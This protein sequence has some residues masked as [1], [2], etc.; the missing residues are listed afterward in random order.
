M[1]RSKGQRQWVCEAYVSLKHFCTEAWRS[2][3][4]QWEISWGLTWSRRLPRTTVASDVPGRKDNRDKSMAQGWGAESPLFQKE[5]RASEGS[6]SVIGRG[7]VSP[8]PCL[9]KEVGGPAQPGS[10]WAPPR[11]CQEARPGSEECGWSFPSR[12]LFMMDRYN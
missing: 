1:W 4:S 2:A 8:W 11:P 7:G 12:C 6:P 9:W 5:A 10:S 3:V